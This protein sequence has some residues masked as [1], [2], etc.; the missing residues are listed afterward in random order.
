MMETEEGE[1]TILD[2][3][4]EDCWR[5]VLQFVP[6]K[7]LIRTERASRRWQEVLLSY[8]KGARVHIAIAEY[9]NEKK[10]NVIGV[11]RS[12]YTSFESWTK[13]LG[14]LVVNTYC[15]GLK[16]LE[17]IKENCPNLVTL[18][19]KDVQCE[20]PELLLRHNL[21]DN[22]KCL[23]RLK[24]ESCK[25]P[26][27]CMNKFVAEK[28]LQ[29]LK[30]YCC[31]SLTGLCLKSMD[32]SNLKLLEINLSKDFES[33]HVLPVFDRMSE[34]KTLK[35]SDVSGE[36]LEEIQIGLDK[37]PKLEK[38]ELDDDERMRGEC[39]QQ[40]SRLTELKHLRLAFQMF[41]EDI[42]A[43]TRCCKELVTLNL[44]DCR[45]M[46]R[47]SVRPIWRNAG[48]RLTELSLMQ[49]Y[50]AKDA[51]IVALIRGCPLLTELT[52][53][54]SRQLTRRLP[55]RAAAARRGVA[56]GKVLDLDLSFT[57]LSSYVCVEDTDADGPHIDVLERQYEGLNIIFF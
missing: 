10:P 18:T 13:K 48:A 38:L 12:L 5:A 41:D 22:F 49:F 26:D 27:S 25:I 21:N 6:I 34:L 23:Q 8:L 44:S 57:N 19:L 9:D 30:F 40:L 52:V 20:T 2:Y 35:V 16:S 29:E 53:T 32:L 15:I 24:L 51:D 1:R 43:I 17:T 50:D 56:P 42:E 37:M 55:A 4:N 3:L 31:D 11:S 14:S 39:G 36:F 46:S 47:R 33:K 28:A 7:D 45:S 54:G